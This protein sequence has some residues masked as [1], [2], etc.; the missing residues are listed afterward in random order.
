MR[1][2]DTS[3]AEQDADLDDREVFDDPGLDAVLLAEQR[4][5]RVTVTVEPVGA[6]ALQ[7][8]PDQLIAELLL[9]AVPV[10]AQLDRGGD[11]TPRCLAVDPD[12]PGD[13]PFTVTVQPAPQRLLDLNH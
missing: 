12:S 13:R 9:T 5:P 7:H 3:A 6:H 4:P 10:D 1:D 8:L 2:D 11:V